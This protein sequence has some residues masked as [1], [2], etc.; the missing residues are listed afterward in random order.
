M[1]PLGSRASRRSARASLGVAASFAGS[2][3]LP[4]GALPLPRHSAPHGGQPVES[5]WKGAGVCPKFV[6]R[7]CRPAWAPPNSP[8]PLAA[9]AR[10]SQFV[11]VVFVVVSGRPLQLAGN[12]KLAICEVSEIKF[13]SFEIIA[14][15]ARRTTNRFNSPPWAQSPL[16]R[17]RRRRQRGRRRRQRRRRR[18][19]WRRMRAANDNL[20]NRA[21]EIRRCP[22]VRPPVCRTGPRASAA[23]SNISIGRPAAGESAL[24]SRLSWTVSAGVSSHD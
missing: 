9:R 10:P 20:A 12:D 19:P 23:P 21:K 13:S 11:A 24:A 17:R 1:P 6:Q 14:G 16:G 15:R 3:E 4:A 18:R 5:H 8:A 7:A 2:G 22:S